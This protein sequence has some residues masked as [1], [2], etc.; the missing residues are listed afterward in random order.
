MM[1][2]AR[3][4]R[5]NV[6]VRSL[7]TPLAKGG[8]VRNESVSWTSE[9]VRVIAVCRIRFRAI[10]NI[11]HRILSCVRYRVIACGLLLVVHPFCRISVA[12]G[13]SNCGTRISA[14]T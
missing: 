3:E 10:C 7:L 4:C 8:V 11:F 14:G 9:V 12:Y 2:S 1:N 5:T 13:F 6:R